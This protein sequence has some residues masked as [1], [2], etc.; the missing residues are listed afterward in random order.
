[1]AKKAKVRMFCKICDRPT[2]HRLRIID[3]QETYVCPHG[4]V[5]PQQNQKSHTENDDFNR[6]DKTIGEMGIWHN[7]PPGMP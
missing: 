1:M 6:L 4:E 5:W 7:L 3:G 2:I